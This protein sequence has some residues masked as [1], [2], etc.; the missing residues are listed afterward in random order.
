VDA[1]QSYLINRFPLGPGFSW[2]YF[3]D[4][5]HSRV[6]RRFI[7]DHVPEG[8]PLATEYRLSAHVANRR[9]LHAIDD[10]LEEWVFFDL[11]GPHYHEKAEIFRDVLQSGRYGLVAFENGY[12]LLRRGHPPGRIADVVRLY[13]RRMEA[14]AL[15]GPTGRNVADRHVPSRFVRV[16]L[17]GIDKSGVLVDGFVRAL[18]PGR[19]VAV[20]TMRA[21]A[22]PG[23][24]RDVASLEVRDEQ[25]TALARRLVTT[26]DFA[27]DTHF[28]LVPLAFDVHEAT[29]VEIRA[30]YTGDVELRID[31]IELQDFGM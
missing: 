24:V 9:V 15:E 6:G 5:E 3:A 16:G 14:E 29:S 21:V 12:T 22:A 7:R 19:Y 10:R 1:Y 23:G 8:V 13:D 31:R 30:R 20:F 28:R 17:P 2:D 18:K 26:E 27:S 4:N 25:R 11:N